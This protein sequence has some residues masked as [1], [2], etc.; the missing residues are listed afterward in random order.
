MDPAALTA[1]L[2]THEHTDHISG[3][4]VF[5]K[6]TDAPVYAPELV[7][8]ALRREFPEH[9][10]RFGTFPLETGCFLGPF[11]VLAFPTPHDTLQSAGW[12]VSA[13]GTVVALAT[14][15]G[16]VTDVMRRY[17][18]GADIALIE[19]NHDPDMLRL[20]PYPPS[21]KRRILS[22]RGHL[23]NHDCAALA[24]ELARGGTKRIVLGH[25]SRENNLPGLA[26]RT[27]R[28]ALADTETVVY[29]APEAGFLR[30]ETEA[31]PCFA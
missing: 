29:A 25:L 31:A 19:A 10:D 6:R 18:A 21:L 1:V 22:D 15:T 24:A 12:R 4:R 9:F 26:L 3:L 11:E 28:A 8:A 7:A 16:R 27:V 23:S 5:L 13:E 17:L 2:I 14:D 20:G 30:V